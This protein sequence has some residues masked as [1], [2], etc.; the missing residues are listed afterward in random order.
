VTL[1]EK[2]VSVKSIT[3]DAKARGVGRVEVTLFLKQLAGKPEETKELLA[4]RKINCRLA[5]NG[6][7]TYRKVTSILVLQELPR[8][9][10]ERCG[11]CQHNLGVLS[12]GGFG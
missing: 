11:A 2:A 9:K 10:G 5:G 7:E 3:T 6:P 4:R 1:C 12:S 8:D